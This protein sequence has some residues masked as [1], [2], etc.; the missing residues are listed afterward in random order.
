MEPKVRILC[1]RSAI[2]I[3]ITRI[4]S[5][6]VKS[7]LRKFSA[8]AEAC[9]P[10]IPPEILVSPSTICAI[11]SPNILRIS[12]T[13]YSVSSTTSCNK[14]AQIEVEPN[15]ISLQ[16]ILAT[17]IGCMIYGSPERRF[18]PSCACLAKLNALVIR[19]TLRR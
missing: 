7:N 5:L 1:R 4:S 14:A 3:K 18:T 2:L 10:K 17:A 16:T 13:V 15:P 11:L 9:S 6:I 19:S 8:C 12:S